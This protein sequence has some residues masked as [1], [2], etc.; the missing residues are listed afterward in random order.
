MLSNLHWRLKFLRFRVVGDSVASSEVN[1]V[2]PVEGGLLSDWNTRVRTQLFCISLY[3]FDR[4]LYLTVFHWFNLSKR[5]YR[6]S[7]LI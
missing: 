4:N 6:D 7:I 1:S 5:K 2:T 3:A